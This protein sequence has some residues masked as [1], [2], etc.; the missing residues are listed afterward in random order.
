ML[1][2]DEVGSADVGLTASSVGSGDFDGF[3]G[4]VG[5]GVGVGLGVELAVGV[6]V[7]VGIGVTGVD[8][9]GSTTR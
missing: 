2:L 7:V 1:L 6:G 4:F 5:L 3:A 9:S 8:E